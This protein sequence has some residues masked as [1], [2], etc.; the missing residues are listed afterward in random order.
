MIAGISMRHGSRMTVMPDSVRAGMTTVVV[1]TTMGLSVD[2]NHR[3]HCRSCV[4]LASVWRLMMSPSLTQPD[5]TFIRKS[6]PASIRISAISSPSALPTTTLSVHRPMRRQNSLHPS[7]LIYSSDLAP[8]PTVHTFQR[9]RTEK[10]PYTCSNLSLL[11]S[12]Q[13]LTRCMK[14]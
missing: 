2:S 11:S 4:A 14:L 8:S 10:Y 13:P 5:E 1:E 9:E 6:S 7:N 12:T 3:C